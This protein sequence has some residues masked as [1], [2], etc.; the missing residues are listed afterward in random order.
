MKQLKQKDCTFYVDDVLHLKLPVSG[1]GGGRQY[2]KQRS[3]VSIEKL[4]HLDFFPFPS[5]QESAGIPL[6]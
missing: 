4:S 2:L 5:R 6:D 3:V 1:K